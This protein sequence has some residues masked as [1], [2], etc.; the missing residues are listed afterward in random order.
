MRWS[1]LLDH[2][3]DPDI[4]E[5]VGH[6]DDFAASL[7][8]ERPGPGDTFS[9]AEFLERVG[10]LREQGWLEFPLDP[11][12]S[13]PL[14][15]AAIE[16]FHRRVLPVP[17]PLVELWSALRVLSRLETPQALAVRE[18]ALSTDS[19][20]LLAVGS[21]FEPGRSG[22]VPFAEAASVIVAVAHGDGVELRLAEPGTAG[23]A[24]ANAPDPTLPSRSVEPGETVLGRLDADALAALRGELL[25]TQSAALA[26]QAEAMLAETTE[27]LTVRH[28]FGV[29]V[30]S[31]QALRHRAADLATEVYAAHRLVRSLAETMPA[32][33]DP[34]LLG[35]IAK[36]FVGAAASRM[37]SE[38]VQLHGGIGFTWEGGVHF[39]LKRIMQLAMTGPTVAV[40]E[41][42]LGRRAVDADALSWAGGLDDLRVSVKED[43]R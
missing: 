12:T 39:G 1:T 5:L 24:V 35:L 43:A 31:F 19:A 15:Q 25:L 7:E 9:D 27:Y 38:A 26:G 28:Q 21:V 23:R 20:V 34:E 3:V 8:A 37:A 30:G 11:D 42:R 40:C 10:A 4:R 14:Y 32:H 36:S 22:W 16:H 29:P 18:S 33:P 17:L 13:E 2:G 41:E 6:W